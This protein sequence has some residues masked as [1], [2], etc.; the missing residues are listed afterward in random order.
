MKPFISLNY[1]KILTSKYSFP[2]SSDGTEFACSTGDPGL[3]PGS[4]RSLQKEMATHSFIFAWRI[5]CTEKPGG[6]QSMWSHSEV[7]VPQSCPTLCNPLDCTVHGILQTRI[8]QWVAF[9]LLQGMFPTQ[10]R[11]PTLQANLYH[12]NTTSYFW[13]RCA[14][15]TFLNNML[16]CESTL[17]KLIP[18]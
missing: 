11:S 16:S 8:L 1:S 7:K 12:L 9:S 4:G 18:T 17:L 5:P 6:L 10:P 14:Q 3:I 15:K 2:G 13:S